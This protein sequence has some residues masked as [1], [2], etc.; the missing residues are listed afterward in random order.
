MRILVDTHV[1]LWALFEPDKIPAD[2]R[3]RLEAADYEIL[4]SAASLWE[5]AIKM[6]IGRIDLPVPPEE[7]ATAAER[8]G[9]VELPV[10]ASHAAGTRRLPM[11]HRDP[12][13]RLLVAQALHEPARLLTADDKLR[14]YSDLVEVIA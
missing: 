1:L 2:A 12:F 8:M 14:P 11:H 9:F 13:D 4:F 7:I 5:I 3:G 6:Q 10:T